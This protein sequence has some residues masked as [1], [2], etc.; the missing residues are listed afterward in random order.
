MGRG[1]R[2]FLW[3]FVLAT[4]IS[5]GIGLPLYGPRIGLSGLPEVPHHHYLLAYGPLLAALIVTMAS[6]GMDGV[7]GLL[8]RAV[9]W[10]VR[11]LWYVAALFG[12]VVVYLM[13]AL[14]VG[15]ATG[16]WVDSSAFGRSAEF[17]GL[18]LGAVWLLHV[19]TFGIGE[20][21]GWRGFALPRLQRG[22]S[23]LAAT[24]ILSVFWAVWHL[25]MFAYHEGFTGAGLGGV[26]GWLVSLV[27][28]AILL[29]WLYNSAHGSILI[30]ILFH[31]SINL[32]FTSETRPL[33]VTSAMGV[34]IVVWAVLVVWFARPAALSRSGKHL[35]GE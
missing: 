3:F 33:S 25:P 30:P 8:Q 5:W 6:R 4:V 14:G 15:V 10:R 7:R 20:E 18:P 35:V 16:Q 28:G 32:A 17:P 1:S 9:K 2:E 13:A 12:P 26:A 19:L 34:I 31:A 21:I 27:A 23:A 11:L 29:T 24:L 22:R